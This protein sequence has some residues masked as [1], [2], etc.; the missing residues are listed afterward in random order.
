MADARAGGVAGATDPA[1]TS[2]AGKSSSGRTL[3]P[4]LA[5]GVSARS[6]SSAATG[7]PATAGA[8][9]TPKRAAPAIGS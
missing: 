4:A 2:G 7:T 3:P 8:A 6:A 9:L 5:A 1:A